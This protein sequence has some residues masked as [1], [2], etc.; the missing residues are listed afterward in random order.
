M[1]FIKPSIEGYRYVKLISSLM[2]M[3]SFEERVVDIYRFE[4]HSI[5]TK[6]GKYSRGAN[7]IPK[8]DYEITVYCDDLDLSLSEQGVITNIMQVI[9]QVN[10]LQALI[11]QKISNI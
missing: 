2:A 10:Q 4:G 5:C 7:A 3:E 1:R 6:I 9:E 8:Y 11:E